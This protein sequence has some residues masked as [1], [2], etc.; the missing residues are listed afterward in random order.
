MIP[1]G[2]HW[3]IGTTDTDWD[4]DKAHPAASREDIDYILDHVNEVLTT[5]L[6]HDAIEG[7]YA[8]LRPLLAGESEASSQRSREHAV[9]RFG[10]Q[11][12][13]REWDQVLTAAARGASERGGAR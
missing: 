4:L 13:L 9:A 2:T 10:L 1:W 6:T 7:V 8:G 12:F 5:P 3:I 11:R